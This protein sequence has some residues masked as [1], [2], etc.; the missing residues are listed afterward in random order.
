MIVFFIVIAILAAF[1]IFILLYY[2]KPYP[3][4]AAIGGE[5][6]LIDTDYYFYGKSQ[7]GFIIF[8]GAKT[9]DLAYAYIAKLLHDEGH[10]VVI[11]KQRF[12]MS[13]FGAK[14]GLEIMQSNPEMATW[15]LIGHSLGGVPVSRIA[16]AQPKGLAGVVFLATYASV[17]LSELDIAALR[18]TAEKD[19]IMNNE[20]MKKYNGNLPNHSTGILLKGANHSGF[21]A[22]RSGSWR[23]R[24]ATITWQDQNEQ[25]VHLILDFFSEQ[26]HTVAG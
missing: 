12:H 24:K 3:E 6:K 7:T 15:V 19:G 21:G 14:H 17:D 22:Y 1:F 4:A 8:A 5:M 10:T 25:T 13:A 23:D 18:I 16:A 20:R 26:I 2:N 11:P 9:D